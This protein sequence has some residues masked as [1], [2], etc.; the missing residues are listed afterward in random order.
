MPQSIFCSV[1]V[2]WCPRL[3]LL[4]CQMSRSKPRSRKT[5]T[6]SS[7][8]PDKRPRHPRS[9]LICNRDEEGSEADSVAPNAASGA[10]NLSPTRAQCHVDVERRRSWISGWWS[11]VQEVSG[12]SH[13]AVIHGHD[14]SVMFQEALDWYLADFEDF[15]MVLWCLV[16]PR[17]KCRC[18]FAL[19]G[20]AN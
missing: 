8:T 3:R 5:A 20:A 19:G 12:H 14:V 13:A 17:L 7:S 9:P 10:K 15:L 4:L 18:V 16:S 1:T 6:S 11:R 2:V